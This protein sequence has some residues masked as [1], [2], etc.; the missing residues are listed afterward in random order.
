LPSQNKR[1]GSGY[2]PADG[3]AL[4][5]FHGMDIFFILYLA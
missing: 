1:I 3:A 4:E 5:A 2:I